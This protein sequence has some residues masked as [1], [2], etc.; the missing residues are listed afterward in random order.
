MLAI[1]SAGVA[2]AFAL[3][4]FF[5]LKDRFTEPLH[6]IIRNF[7]YGA[8]LVFPIMFMQYALEAEG[9]GNGDFVQ[10]FLIIGFMEEFFKWF[11]FIYT[12]YH[13]TEFDAHYDG[14]VYAVAISLGFATVEN[15]LYLLSNGIEYAFSRALF[16]VS[17][18][19]LFGVI[20]G[21]YL[22]KAK[23]EQ[24]QKKM[25]LTFALTI[26][27]L[28]H[29]VYNYILIKVA[30]DWLILLVPF[31]IFLWVI[32]LRRV[33]VANASKVSATLSNKSS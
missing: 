17:S 32:A 19:A 20:M 2:P 21:F 16:P 8:I 14:I 25:N 18:H 12:I 13:H 22:G 3:M 23:M 31:M 27:F 11:I 26:P 15:S 29:G 33:K 28:L 4:S 7:I 5:Y 9:I 1:L 30:S 10:S 6:L 24:H